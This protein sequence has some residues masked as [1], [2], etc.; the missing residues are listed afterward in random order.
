METREKIRKVFSTLRKK[1]FFARMNFHCCMNCALNDIP[2]GTKN[3]VY[4]H[5]Q[6]G[7][8][9]DKTGKCYLGWGGDVDTIL[10]ACKEA[11]LKVEW[12]GDHRKRIIVK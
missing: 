11:G 9:L 8:D 5:K 1:D 4:F 12:D 3:F 6:D 7:E 2:E 10:S